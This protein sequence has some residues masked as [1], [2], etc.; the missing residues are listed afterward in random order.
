MDCALIFSLT[1]RPILFTCT[2]DSVATVSPQSHVTDL[3]LVSNALSTLVKAEQ[4][5]AWQKLFMVQLHHEIRRSHFLPLQEVI[6]LIL[7]LKL[8]RALLLQMSLNNNSLFNPFCTFLKWCEKLT[9]IET[10]ALHRTLNPL[11]HIS[12]LKK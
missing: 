3:V 5:Y 10:E 1:G 12:A 4:T 9:S 8:D 7:N 6:L 11:F 2:S